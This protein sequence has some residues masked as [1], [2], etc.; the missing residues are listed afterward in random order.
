M[1]EYW[2]TEF[3]DDF[4]G[5]SV[6]RDFITMGFAYC[7]R[8]CKFT[9]KGAVMSEIADAISEKYEGGTVHKNLL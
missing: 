6:D 2:D 7:A 9:V 5:E 1:Q 4:A 3:L 8:Q